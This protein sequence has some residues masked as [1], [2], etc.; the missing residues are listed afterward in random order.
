MPLFARNSADHLRCVFNQEAK[1]RSCSNQ[2]CDKCLN[3]RLPSLC[4]HHQRLARLYFS[5][6]KFRESFASFDESLY[7]AF[8]L[9][10]MQDERYMNDFEAEGQYEEIIKAVS[11]LTTLSIT[12]KTRQKPKPTT[13]VF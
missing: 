8:K 3:R 12:I 4:F 6:G 5:E 10:E 11:R 7:W 2:T 1:F 9:E 13:C